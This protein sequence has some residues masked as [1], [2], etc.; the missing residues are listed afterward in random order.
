MPVVASL[1]TCAAPEA[2]EP[3]PE[4]SSSPPVSMARELFPACDDEI[5][6]FLNLATVAHLF[7]AANG[8]DWSGLLTAKRQDVLRCVETNYVGAPI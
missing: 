3:E 4:I 5:R 6:E 1:L 2:L 7:M 8:S